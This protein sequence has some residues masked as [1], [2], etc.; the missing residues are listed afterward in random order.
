MCNVRIFILLVPVIWA[1]CMSIDQIAPPVTPGMARHGSAATLQRGRELY[2]GRCTACHTPQPVAKYGAAKWG[3]IL[4]EMSDEAK[5]SKTDEAAVV[6]Y[7]LAAR[8]VT[9]P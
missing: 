6:A 4:V 9:A 5:L 3:E 2:T 1:G 8:Q 7:V